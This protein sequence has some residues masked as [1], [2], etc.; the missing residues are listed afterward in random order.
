MRQTLQRELQRIEADAHKEIF[1]S[2]Y[3]AL[4]RHALRLTDGS[5]PRAEDLLHDAFIQFVLQSPD[6]NSIDNLDGYLYRLLLNL[7]RAQKRKAAQMQDISLNIADYDSIRLGLN[8]IDAQARWQA[9]EDLIQICHYACVRK[10]TSRAGSI[11]ILRFF[12]DYS[13]SEIAKVT[14]S[15]RR[16]VDDWLRLAR[17]EARSYLEDPGRL[18]FMAR[19]QDENHGLRTRPSKSSDDILC[20]LLTY[21]QHSCWNECLPEAQLRAHYQDSKG[22][23]VKNTMDC[24]TL[25]HIVS[26][27]CC[28]DRV[29]Q[30]LGLPSLSARQVIDNVNSD[31][32]GPDDSDNGGTGGAGTGGE[33]GK[34]F[35]D[36]CCEGLRQIVEHRPEE[37]HISANGVHIGALKVNSELSELQFSIQDQSPVEFIEVF[38]ERGMRLILFSLEYGD[39]ALVEQ[40]ARIELSEERTLELI[41]EIGGSSPSLHV[42]YHDPMFQEVNHREAGADVVTRTADLG[43]E[44]LITRLSRRLCGQLPRQLLRLILRRRINHK[45]TML[46]IFSEPQSVYGKPETKTSTELTHEPGSEA[47]HIEELDVFELGRAQDL[48]RGPLWERPGFIAVIFTVLLGAALFYLLMPGATA[49]TAAS[50]LE[51]AGLAEDKIAHNP[52]L[53]QHRMLELEERRP[54]DG[55]VISRSRIEIW[56]SGA[57]GVRMKRLY[58]QRNRLIAREWT[59]ADGSR[60][61]DRLKGAYGPGGLEVWQLEFSAQDF[62]ALVKQV[63]VATVEETAQTYVI[64]Y[65]PAGRQLI[66]PPAELTKA[67]ITLNKRDLHTIE[68]TLQIQQTNE[69]REFRFS[70]TS[71]QQIPA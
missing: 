68:Q 40:R 63:D 14:L 71:Y 31:S 24:T 48:I 67:S 1:L 18:K 10:E 41:F 4:F 19:K 5:R 7:F 64:S 61:I 54:R 44:G 42:S 56:H 65:Q 47:P 34:A 49:V 26:C 21:I 25:G 39:C 55:R 57:Q 30:L 23:Q 60:K 69:T 58:D 43:S 33:P 51:R 12:Y 70:E 28:L 11:L 3:Q 35:I 37:L 2:H 6:L 38:S 52:G 27:T 46:S 62:S 29:N 50:L 9:Q 13:P 32:D 15:P 59:G 53:V 16:A 8:A 22:G 66:L 36:R 17:R 45:L 20:E